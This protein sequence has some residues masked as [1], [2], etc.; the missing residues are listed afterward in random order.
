MTLLWEKRRCAV[1]RMTAG[2]VRHVKRKGMKN[3]K[4]QNESPFCN[5]ETSF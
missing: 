5:D 1:A 2:V 3:N 4:G